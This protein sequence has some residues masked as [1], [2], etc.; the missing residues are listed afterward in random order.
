[1]EYKGQVEDRTAGEYQGGEEP[2]IQK[3]ILSLLA[4]MWRRCEEN[5]KEA[6]AQS[7]GE[8]LPGE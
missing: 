7:F 2:M 8:S 1:M 3:G 6:H 4:E 5:V